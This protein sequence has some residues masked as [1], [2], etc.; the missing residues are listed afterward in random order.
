VKREIIAI[1]EDEHV[2]ESK[3]TEA[4]SRHFCASAREIFT[5]ILEQCALTMKSGKRSR[6]AHFMMVGRRG[7]LGFSSP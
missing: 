6:I 1:V 3:P 5:T 4:A 7:D 2:A